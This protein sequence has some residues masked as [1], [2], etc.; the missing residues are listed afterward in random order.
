M[1]Q[2]NLRPSAISTVWRGMSSN[3]EFMTVFWVWDTSQVSG[4]QND[5]V[6]PSHPAPTLEK[7]RP[8]DKWHQ[9]WLGLQ[10]SGLWWR[11]PV[12][13]HPL[14]PVST[15][16]PSTLGC[17]SETYHFLLLLWLAL[18]QNQCQEQCTVRNWVTEMDLRSTEWSRKSGNAFCFK[19][20]GLFLMASCLIFPIHFSLKHFSLAS[21]PGLRG[22]GI[23]FLAE[24]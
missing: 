16:D 13:S 6:Q 17:R 20:W 5:R 9:E 10:A 2:R 14:R 23:L 22:K 7:R 15:S 4:W 19:Q 3:A 21:D 24:C 1:L 12:P 11:G 8:S 18:T